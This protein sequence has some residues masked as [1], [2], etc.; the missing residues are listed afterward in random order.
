MDTLELLSA[1]IKAKKPFSFEYHADGHVKGVRTGNPHAIFIHPTTD[2]INVD[3]WKTDGVSTKPDTVLPAWKQY[4][5]EFIKNIT[6]L[7]HEATFEP[8]KGYNPV[9]K[10]YSRVIVKI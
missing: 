6:I 4:R 9:S 10:Q 7:E 3:I 1:A 8:A 2:N 5:L